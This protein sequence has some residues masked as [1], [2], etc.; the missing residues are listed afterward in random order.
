MSGKNKNINKFNILIT[1]YNRSLRLKRLLKYY[2]DYKEAYNVIIADSSSDE[3]KKE[4][5]KTVE[6]LSNIKV[7]LLNNYSPEHGDFGRVMHKIVDAVDHV[8]EEYCIVVADDDFVTPTLLNKSVDFLEKN[9]D[10]SVVLGN[11]ISFTVKNDEYGNKQFYWEKHKQ[12]G[13]LTIPDV[14]DRL[15]YYFS[16]YRNYPSPTQGIYRTDTMKE[17]WGEAANFSNDG[18]FGEILSNTMSVL[19]GKIKWIDVFHGAREY[20][21]P[22]CLSL[23]ID[24]LS[25]YMAK[26]TFHE[27]YF[28]LK[29][30]LVK[31]LSEKSKIEMKEAEKVVEKG[32]SVYTKKYKGFLTPKLNHM[33]N[34]MHLP[35]KFDKTVRKMFRKIS[36]KNKPSQSDVNVPLKK[37]AS[38]PPSEWIVDFEKIKKHALTYSEKEGL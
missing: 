17:V 7:S 28:G 36:N 25:D 20:R 30:C 33:I 22:D 23:S 11:L 38:D 32:W 6:S 26:G 9:K 3:I 12:F 5:K 16:N 24:R 2:D 18:A 29:K 14:K 19:C 8:K 10:Y 15:L 37:T 21:P 13:S 35:S 27:R 34:N 4:N 31:N 1:T